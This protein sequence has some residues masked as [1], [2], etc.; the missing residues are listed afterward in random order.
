MDI[1]L[2]SVSLI[3]LILLGAPIALAMIVLPTIYI[4][5]TDAAPLLTVP[6]QMYEALARFPLVAIPFF[7]LTGE[8]MNSSSVTRRILRLSSVLVGKMRGGLAQV[9]MVASLFF[10]GMN[11]SAV[12][13]TATIG[14][15]MIPTMRERGYSA[16]YAAAITAIGS[17]IGGIIPPSIAMI[18]LASVANLSVGA[19]FAGG[20]LPGLLITFMLMFVVW[21]IARREGHERGE[22]AFSFAALMS[23]FGAA[24]LALS[25]PAIL[26]MGILGGWFSSVEAG[27]ITAAVAFF[28]GAVAYRDMSRKAAIQALSRTVRLSG[29][30]FIIIAAAG[31]FSWLLTRL[32][33]LDLLEAWLGTFAG[34][35]LAF[36]A[37][38]LLIVF[39]AG[40]F[41]DATANI[42][43]LGPML[44]PVSVAAGYEPIQAAL[45]VV[46]GFLLGTV[47]PPVGVCYFTAA[48]V[49]GA[50]LDRTAIALLPFITIE[51]LVLFL[52][53]L[54]APL[55]LAIPAWLGLL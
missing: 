37:A 32:G 54:V 30:V 12:A 13:D 34:S 29:S 3:C 31:P 41:M 26:I 55:T 44:I 18:V 43:V 46:V 20:I 11:G 51:I 4:L 42:I 50:R 17:T 21:V 19:L 47:T 10:A 48:A 45:V 8:L 1:L 36:A 27:A 9:N 16:P 23:A 6:H 14:T 25:V 35:P 33:A 28:I 52:M 49:A 5:I 38:L 22:V 15:V 39:V 24:A 53:L 2:L 40:M 7:M